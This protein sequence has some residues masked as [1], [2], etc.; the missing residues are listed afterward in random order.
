MKILDQ[1]KSIDENICENID[2]NS[3]L[4]DRGFLSQNILSQ[5]RNLVEHC[6][7]YINLRLNG[8]DDNISLEDAK[9]KIPSIPNKIGDMNNEFRFIKK[10]HNLLQ[11]SESHYA[12]DKNNSERLMLKYYEYMLRLKKLCIKT[13]DLKIL[14]NLHKFPLELD[15]NLDEYYEKILSKLNQIGDF[16]LKNQEII[17]NRYK[18][19]IMYGRLNR[20]L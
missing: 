12:H 3:T 19:D 18:I 9:E 2:K 8:L 4:N 16:R 14:S 10:F 6:S 7:M 1:I 15:K 11:V 17:K 5:L 13:L 20:F